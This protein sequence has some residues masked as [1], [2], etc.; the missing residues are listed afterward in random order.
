MHQHINPNP[1]KPETNKDVGE[2]F[3]DNFNQQET[4]TF[5]RT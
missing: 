2:I 1:K 3:L 4:S 5:F